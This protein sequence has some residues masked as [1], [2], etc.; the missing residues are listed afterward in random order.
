MIP[1][2][3]SQ[4]GSNIKAKY[5]I[6]GKNHVLKRAATAMVQPSLRTRLSLTTPHTE[7]QNRECE[8][9]S[10][11]THRDAEQRV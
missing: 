3:L 10:Q 2:T 1:P 5:G 4:G 6:P 7:M 8:T 9:V 11:H